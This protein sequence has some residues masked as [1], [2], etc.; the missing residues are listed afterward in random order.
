MYFPAMLSCYKLCRPSYRPDK[1]KPPRH[2]KQPLVW[3][4][5]EMTGA[6]RLARHVPEGLTLSIK[7]SS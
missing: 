4:D 1:K 3:L 7:R 2:V 5:L 6:L